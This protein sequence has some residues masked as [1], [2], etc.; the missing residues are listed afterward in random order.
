M[1]N[2]AKVNGNV[3]ETL[4]K[5]NVLES[6]WKEKGREKSLEYSRVLASTKYTLLSWTRSKSIVKEE[7]NIWLFI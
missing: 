4:K 7:G 5:R 1:N 2:E 3:G 6:A